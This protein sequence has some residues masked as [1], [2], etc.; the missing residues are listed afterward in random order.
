MTK[1]NLHL[2]VCLKIV[3]DLAFHLMLRGTATKVGTENYISLWSSSWHRAPSASQVN[4][5]FYCNCCNLSYFLSLFSFSIFSFLPSSFSFPFCLSSF[6]LPFPIPFLPYTHLSTLRIN[7]RVE[8]AVKIS[9]QTQQ[10]Q[11]MREKGRE[12]RRGGKGYLPWSGSKDWL[13]RRQMWP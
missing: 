13:E 12:Q 5:H 6:S 7:I 2:M 8:K 3:A 11:R 9:S 1:E 4:S 10:R